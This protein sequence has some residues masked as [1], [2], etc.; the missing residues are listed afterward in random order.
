M[1]LCL[2]LLASTLLASLLPSTFATTNSEDKEA[3]NLTVAL[4]KVGK[5]LAKLRPRESRLTNCKIQ[6]VSSFRVKP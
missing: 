4:H 1:R 5:H 3:I 2:F 6:G